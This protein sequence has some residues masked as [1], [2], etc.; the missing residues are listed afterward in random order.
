MN[1][2]KVVQSVESAEKTAR[3]ES[4][5]KAAPTMRIKS[6]LKAGRILTKC[7]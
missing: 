2:E 5:E 3:V 4:Q 6:T 1:Q 7:D